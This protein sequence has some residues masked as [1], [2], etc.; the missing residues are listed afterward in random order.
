MAVSL[1]LDIAVMY[2]GRISRS[3]YFGAM[4]LKIGLQNVLH[5]KSLLS[6]VSPSEDIDDGHRKKVTAQNRFCNCSFKVLCI[7]MA[8]TYHSFC[9]SFASIDIAHLE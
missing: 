4:D 3:V 9:C 8:T 6:A 1:T 7:T 2:I 5:R